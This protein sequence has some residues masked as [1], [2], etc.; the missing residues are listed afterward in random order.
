MVFVKR[1]ISCLIWS[2]W[3]GTLKLSAKLV[4]CETAIIC[5]FDLIYYKGCTNKVSGRCFNSC[6]QEDIFC[7]PYH[8]CILRTPGWYGPLISLQKRQHFFAKKLMHCL[9]LQKFKCYIMQK[10]HVVA[11][12]RREA[13]CT[14]VMRPAFTVIAL[15]SLLSLKYSK[16]TMQ[17]LLSSS[18]TS[19]PKTNVFDFFPLRFTPTTSPTDLSEHN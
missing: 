17:T 10:L 15:H 14:G 12:A 6:V 2:G 9:Y 11:Y 18:D 19:Y 5:Y 1:D 4:E 3:Y 16:K 13:G 7:V 8:P